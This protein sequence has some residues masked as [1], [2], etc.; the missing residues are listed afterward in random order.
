DQLENEKN[1]NPANASAIDK[2][3]QTL[4]TIKS[5]KQGEINLNNDRI[6]Q[7]DGGTSSTRPAMN[8]AAVMPDYDQKMAAIDQKNLEEKNELTEKNALNN[9]LISAID[10]KIAQLENEKKNNPANADA[11]NKDIQT[12]QNIKSQKQG[13][14][15]ANNDRI[16]QLD[17]GTSSSRPAMNIAAVMPDYDQKMAAIEQ[18]NLDE[19]N[20]LTEKNA[21]NNQLI[22]AIDSKI[23]QLEN[24]KKSNLANADAINKDIQ[25][26]Q[27]IKSQKQGEIN[28]NNERIKQLDGGVTA[29]RSAITISSIMPDYDQKMAAIEKKNLDEKNDL[30]EKNGVNNQLISAI[31]SKIAQLENEKQNN[32]SNAAGIDKDIQTLEGIKAQKQTEINLNNERIKQ[33]ESG[34][35]SSR[36]VLT[37]SSIMPDY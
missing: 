30:T 9:Q 4:N 28:A 7:L 16:K 26:L 24:E 11:I 31:D 19:K 6:K 14:I 21:L 18:K 33:L 2:D 35:T 36:P 1:L 37:I 12:L 17:G 23:A 3:I 5:Q 20:E 8:I 22:S 15:N 32:P 34:D 29:T 10:S 13:E 25:T 27:N